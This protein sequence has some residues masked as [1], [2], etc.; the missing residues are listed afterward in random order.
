[1]TCTH[2]KLWHIEKDGKDYGNL[3]HKRRQIK[4]ESRVDQEGWQYSHGSRS[5]NWLGE[6]KDDAHI[7]YLR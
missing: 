2:G 7:L 1:M 4:M 6:E 5:L 3:Q